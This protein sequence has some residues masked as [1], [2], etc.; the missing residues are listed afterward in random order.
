[1]RPHSRGFASLVWRIVI[2]VAVSVLFTVLLVWL[3]A[4][5]GVS[6]VYTAP[7]A[8]TAATLVAWAF[9]RNMVEPL[10]QV[11]RA[12]TIMSRGDYGVRVT[13]QTTDE[14]GQ[15]AIAFNTMA[16]DLAEIDR[17][18]REVVANVSHELRTPVAALRARLENMADGVEAPTT[19]NLE[20]AVVQVEHL[21]RLLAYLLD[22]SRVESGA[23][24]LE[25]QS[26]S[27]AGLIDDAVEVAR[28]AAGRRGITINFAARVEPT[29]VAIIGDRTR[30]LQV[31]TNVLDNATRHS[32]PGSTVTLEAVRVRQNLRIDITDTGRGIVA[33]DRERIF[34]RFQR[35]SG[36]SA[37]GGGSGLGL[38][39]ARWAVSLHAGTI[40]V[41]DSEIGARFRIVLPLVPPKQSQPDS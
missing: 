32:P 4:I 29:E 10:R 7:L 34:R 37:V 19:E 13:P 5:Q 26:I 12:A 40:A 39:I 27:V 1:M 20:A 15:L 16:Q 35:G 9:A 22:V 33:S 25:L 36:S 38:A 3:G 41:V 6:P 11:T 23:A 8:I 14:V 31:L 21:S 2:L 18:H 30:L 17:L 28:L 24:G